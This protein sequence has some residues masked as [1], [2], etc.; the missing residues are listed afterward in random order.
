M[1]KE[2]KLGSRKS[3][4]LDDDIIQDL[5]GLTRELNQPI[6]HPGNPILKP[7]EAW[8]FFHGTSVHYDEEEKIYKMWHGVQKGQIMESGSLGY[9]T[10]VDG[11]NWER[12]KLGLFEWGG[13]KENNVVFPPLKWATY[14][15]IKDLHE[16]DHA[17]RYKAL[18][19][20]CTEDM[21]DMGYYQPVCA[22]YSP[23]GIHWNARLHRNPVLGGMG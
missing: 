18:F 17:K 13:N 19:H 15:V 11:L 10:S 9:A 8:E 4:F 22:A 6:K 1:G 12:P 21:A 3:L 14:G 2:V 7:D 23:D 16:T 20:F 5:Q